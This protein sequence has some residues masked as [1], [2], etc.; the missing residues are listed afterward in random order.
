M[1]AYGVNW[2]KVLVYSELITKYQSTYQIQK[3][4]SEKMKKI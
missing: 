3:I 1:L 4:Y 2:F